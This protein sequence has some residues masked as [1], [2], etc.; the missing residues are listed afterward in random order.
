MKL[1]RRAFLATC[2]AVAAGSALSAGPT[3]ASQRN[4]VL[5]VADDYRAD[6]LGCAGHPFLQTPNLDRVAREGVRYTNAC[7]TSAICCASRAGILTGMHPAR[8]RVIDFNT[9]I[10]REHWHVTYPQ[11]LR[12]NG[13]RTG[14]FGK[15]GVNGNAAP[16][17]AFDVVQPPAHGMLYFPKDAPDARHADDL[18]TSAAE[19]FIEAQAAA[20]QP[21]CVSLSF[22]TPHA[23]DYVD[24]PYQ[25]APEFQSLYEDVV[26]PPAEERGAPGYEI[27]PEFLKDSE[28]RRR[29][30]HNFGGVERYQESARNYFRSITGMDA[31]IG[32]LLSTLE[33]AGVAQTTLVVFVGDNGYF[34]GER[35]LEGKWYAYEQSIRVPLL[36]LDPT[37]PAEMRGTTDERLVNECD[38]AP[39]LLDFAGIAVPEQMQGRSIRGRQDAGTAWR[40]DCLYHHHFKHPRIPRSEGVV[41][42]DWK[43]IRWIDGSPGYEE[44]Y[45]LQNDPWETVNLAF[46]ARHVET[47]EVMRRRHYELLSAMA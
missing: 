6:F 18:H 2:S 3:N 14:F 4:L 34:L 9:D 27:L 44:L 29:Y 25:P 45:D 22:Q 17:A 39:T 32:R 12:A 11:I 23:I 8:H 36:V 33:R 41:S 47:R 31:Y 15:Y 40:T 43:Y 24:K 19:S 10:R 37:A 42:K 28:G 16:E 26:V 30:L 7:I 35:G 5:I 13:Y 38:I 46:E 20:G 1:S 21:F